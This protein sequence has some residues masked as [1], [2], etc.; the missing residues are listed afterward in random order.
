MPIEIIIRNIKR[1]INDYRVYFYTLMIFSMIFYVFNAVG[2]DI[3]GRSFNIG[4]INIFVSLIFSLLLLYANH[5]MI[6]QR[7]PEFMNLALL[8]MSFRDITLVLCLETIVVILLSLILGLTSGIFVSQLVNLFL[9]YYLYGSAAGYRFSLSSSAFL[10]II[11]LYGIVIFFLCAFNSLSVGRIKMHLLLREDYVRS[12]RITQIGYA[13]PTIYLLLSL[14]IV[15][16]N[17]R[18]LVDRLDSLSVFVLILTFVL[19]VISILLMIRSAFLFLSAFASSEKGYK[20]VFEVRFITDNGNELTYLMTAVSVTI[21]ISFVL[22]AGSF[23]IINNLRKLSIEDMPCDLMIEGPGDVLSELE[24]NGIVISDHLSSWEQAYIY[25]DPDITYTSMFLDRSLL[26]DRYYYLDPEQCIDIMSVSDYNRLTV[27]YDNDPVVLDEDEFLLT[28]D[29]PSFKKA[30]DESLS[31]DNMMMI[32]GY[33]LKSISSSCVDATVYLNLS[34]S[35]TGLLIVPDNVVVACIPKGSILLGEQILDKAGEGLVSLAIERLVP[36]GYHLETASMIKDDYRRLTIDTMYVC[37]YT[38]SVFIICSMAVL[39]F[40]EMIT[41]GRRSSMLKSLTLM[42]FPDEEIRRYFVCHITTIF[43]CTAIASYI[44]SGYLIR[45]INRFVETVGT[46]D[47][48]LSY[49][50]YSAFLFPFLIA[51]AVLTYKTSS[52]L[53]FRVRSNSYG[54]Y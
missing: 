26:T 34:K 51:F 47:I 33:E 13:R 12:K 2:D 4:K 48:P 36:H 3:S 27:I 17:R 7:R 10:G 6:R 21:L 44:H 37:L 24:D 54:K 39:S 35:N 31:S 52:D 41:I 14:I 45:V 1:S 43:S 28:S 32:N 20:Y 22:V 49:T 19:S 46:F 40:K 9:R 53:C 5:F 16:I 29:L 15:F 8:G 38:S 42:G 11:K 18:L 50:V 23:G 30:Y 25:N